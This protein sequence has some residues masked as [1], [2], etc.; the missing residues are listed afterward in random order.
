[1]CLNVMGVGLSLIPDSPSEC[2]AGEWT[3]PRIVEISRSVGMASK[4][5]VSC[6]EVLPSTLT[7]PWHDE[8]ILPPLAQDRRELLLKC[9]AVNP[10]LRGRATDGIDY[11]TDG[12]LEAI[13]QLTGE[14]I[15][16]RRDVCLRGTGSFPS[17]R[18]VVVELI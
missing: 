2:V 14:V 6:L 5:C 9:G 4:R 12:Y 11:D 15:G 7:Y 10:R 18:A 8:V 1:M 13:S 3:D 16:D 17:G